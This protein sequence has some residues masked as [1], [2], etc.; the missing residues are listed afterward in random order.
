MFRSIKL[1]G[2]FFDGNAPECAFFH[3]A[4]MSFTRLHDNTH[5]YIAEMRSSSSCVGTSVV[6][7]S[8]TQVVGEL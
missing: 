5:R 2:N 6:A 8:S 1:L 7:D 3:S 4:F